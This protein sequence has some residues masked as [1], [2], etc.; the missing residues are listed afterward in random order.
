MKKDSEGGT[1]SH[2]F[3]ILEVSRVS[4]QRKCEGERGE[5]RICPGCS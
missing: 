3:Q 4:D 1:N 2:Y 5:E